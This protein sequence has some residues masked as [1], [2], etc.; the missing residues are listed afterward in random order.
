MSST[1]SELKQQPGKYA[2]PTVTLSLARVALL[3]SLFLPYW[4]MELVAPQYPKGL[5]LTAYVNRV[6]GHV[7]EINGLNLSQFP[8]TQASTQ[9]ST[10]PFLPTTLPA[11]RP[12]EFAD[13]GR[14]HESGQ[15][16]VDRQRQQRG[17][18]HDRASA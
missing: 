10:Q 1:G 2:L 8:T 15:P 7:R 12:V 13:S 5:H 17:W 4:H 9:P 3:A 18:L 14:G 11:T 16:V 6:E